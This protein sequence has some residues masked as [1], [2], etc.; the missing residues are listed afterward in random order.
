MNKA[1]AKSLKSGFQKTK[2]SSDL[3]FGLLEKHDV[4]WTCAY[5]SSMK[6]NSWVFLASPTLK[7]MH[8]I[9]ASDFTPITTW[10][11]HA[12]L[13]CKLTEPALSHTSWQEVDVSHGISDYRGGAT[14]WP[15]GAVAPSRIMETSHVLLY[16]IPRF[17][18]WCTVSFFF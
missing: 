3:P 1:W 17:V 11:K 12:V 10:I 4:M 6:L 14:W 18:D 9:P 8:F 5:Y 7:D 16:F 2:H 13:L 15:L